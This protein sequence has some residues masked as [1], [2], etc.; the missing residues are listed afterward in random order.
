MRSLIDIRRSSISA[1]SYE[2]SE[3]RIPFVWGKKNGVSART[4]ELA[5]S[6]D[7]GVLVGGR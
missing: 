5:Q 6:I 3:C 2:E 1:I 4:D 7:V